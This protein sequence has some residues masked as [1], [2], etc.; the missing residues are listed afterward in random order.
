MTSEKKR[1]WLLL[2]HEVVSALNAPASE[3]VSGRSCECVNCLEPWQ[4]AARGVTGA[5]TTYYA[6]GLHKAGTSLMGAALAARLGGGYEVEALYYCKPIR[7]VHRVGL[8][9]DAYPTA[10]H[11][12]MDSFDAYFCQCGHTMVR[13][14]FAHHLY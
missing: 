1:M 9:S 10:P 5:R 4:S 8:S 13:L 14:A 3:Q 12:F 7:S 2:L 6:M 11:F